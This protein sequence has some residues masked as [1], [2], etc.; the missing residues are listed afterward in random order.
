MGGND[1]MRVFEIDKQTIEVY[2]IN[3]DEFQKF[4]TRYNFDFKARPFRPR[5][6]YE[7]LLG[8]ILG[9][10]YKAPVI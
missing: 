8:V 2:G 5:R 10:K 1:K 3:E 7:R 4:L 9:I 6:W